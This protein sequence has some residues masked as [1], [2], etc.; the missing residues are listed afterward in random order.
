M[1]ELPQDGHS[2]RGGAYISGVKQETADYAKRRLEEHER[3]FMKLAAMFA[4]EFADESLLGEIEK[5]DN[6]FPWIFG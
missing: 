4:G 2:F 3:D 5:R 1:K 6:L